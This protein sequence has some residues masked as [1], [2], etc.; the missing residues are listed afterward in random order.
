MLID[1]KTNLTRLKW[2]ILKIPIMLGWLFLFSVG[3]WIAVH[4]VALFG[5]F[6]IVAYP[7][8]SFLV[9]RSHT[10]PHWKKVL[11]AELIIVAFTL[12]SLLMVYGEYRV[13]STFFPSVAS[14]TATFDLPDETRHGIGELFPLPIVL[15]DLPS[16]INLVQADFAFDSK[17]IELIDIT[18]SP[19]FATVFI[20]KEISNESGYGRIVGGLPNP[21]YSG[22]RGLF[23]TA[24][25][26]AKEAGTATVRFLPTSRALANDGFG[27]DVLKELAS[28]VYII[29]NESVIPDSIVPSVPPQSNSG[30]II[31]G[32]SEG[33]DSTTSSSG[34]L[35]FYDT[36]EDGVRVL[37]R[38]PL[39]LRAVGEAL[40]TTK[41]RTQTLWEKFW[42]T[43]QALDSKILSLLGL[44]HD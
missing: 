15:A 11:S 32:S 25:F 14:Q 18:T 16:P 24:Y 35:T 12:T 37:G 5:I 10:L 17:Y 41:T 9:S 23:A 1:N 19:S 21:G 2:A 22:E 6:F 8:W 3:S 39:S 30:L 33:L 28:A 27:T 44:K 34:P 4:L 7:V 26:K 38:E 40:E 20:Q 43:L 36:S 42:K 13:I 31:G 29:Q